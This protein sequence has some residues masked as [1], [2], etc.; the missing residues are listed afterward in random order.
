[1]AENLMQNALGKR[2]LD[3]SVKVKV[4]FDCDER[5]QFTV[6]DTGAPVPDDIMR[7]LLRGPVHSESGYGVG[8]YQVARQARE[9]GFEL[10]IVSN[11]PGRVCFQ[12]AGA[13]S[14]E[15]SVLAA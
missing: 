4:R 3:P 5:V 13:L 10:S 2:R 9:A 14:A 15:R 12:L 6:F 11:L 1:A 8:L 7:K